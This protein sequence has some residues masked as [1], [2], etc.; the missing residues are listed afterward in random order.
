MATQATTATPLEAAMQ[1]LATRLRLTAAAAGLPDFALSARTM[2][3]SQGASFST[4]TLLATTPSL[5]WHDAPIAVEASTLDRVEI[6]FLDAL[7]EYGF[8]TT[9]SMHQEQPQVF[10]DQQLAS[11]LALAAAA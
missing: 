11:V 7:A 9:D 1:E 6:M 4:Y 5:E 2:H 8:R 10:G 3:R